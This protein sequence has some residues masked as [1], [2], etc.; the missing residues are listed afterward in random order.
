MD[1]C[2]PRLMPVPKAGRRYFGLGKNA[3]YE[4]AR[5]GEVPTI[6]I[7]GRLFATAPLLERKLDGGVEKRPAG[8][9]P[10]TPLAD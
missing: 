5:T 8:G 6:K 4:A 7:G 1:E 9:A 10:V 3:S 2:D